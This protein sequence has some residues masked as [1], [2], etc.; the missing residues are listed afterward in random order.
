[1][2]HKH[3]SKKLRMSHGIMNFH[4]I[5][6]LR[7]FYMSTYQQKKLQHVNNLKHTLNLNEAQNITI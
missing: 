6:N 2:G 7:S 5:L 1:M 4:K 3:S